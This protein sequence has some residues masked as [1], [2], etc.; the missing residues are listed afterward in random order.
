MQASHALYSFLM[1]IKIISE[2]CGK[3]LVEKVDLSPC[4]TQNHRCHSQPRHRFF[5][6]SVRLKQN[7]KK[8]QAS[9]ALYSFLVLHFDNDSTIK[10]QRGSEIEFLMDSGN[11][12]SIMNDKSWCY[13]K[14][15]K[16]IVLN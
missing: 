10:C 14:K 13:L 5:S 11:K 3:R 9:H 8:T 7:Y 1:L 2:L 12:H 16:A 4:E 6:D 15:C